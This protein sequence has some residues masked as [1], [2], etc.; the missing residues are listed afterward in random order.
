MDRETESSL[1]EK[2]T[3]IKDGAS[4]ADTFKDGSKLF[5]VCYRQLFLIEIEIDYKKKQ[6]T[7]T[8]WPNFLE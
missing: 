5:H 2:K 3:E 8:S 6:Q 7:L 4:R 1:R